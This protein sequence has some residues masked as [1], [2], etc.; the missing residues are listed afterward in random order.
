MAMLFETGTEEAQRLLAKLEP[1]AAEPEPPCW[2]IGTDEG[3]SYCRACA[4]AAL[5]AGRGTA[6]DGGY[7]PP[8]EADGCEVCETC[9]ALLGYTLTDWGVE[10]ETAHFTEQPPAA[11]LSPGEAYEVCRILWGAPDNEEVLRIGR[12]A[13]AAMPTP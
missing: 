9:G 5:A 2:L 11:P 4:E 1:Y 13:V 12:A 3:S 7:D 8:P 10:T 6:I